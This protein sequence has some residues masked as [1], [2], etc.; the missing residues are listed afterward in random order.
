MTG[1]MQTIAQTEKKAE[2]ITEAA[3]EY[4]AAAVTGL[5]K[6]IFDHQAQLNSRGNTQKMETE[7]GNLKV[8]GRWIT[9]YQILDGT[10][11]EYT[12]DKDRIA[13]A[14]ELAR[15]ELPQKCKGVPDFNK[16]KR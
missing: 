7:F 11:P 12:T 5:K 3:S 16:D 8:V 2:A 10:N 6:F 1:R 9:I 14:I 15:L 13:A 4:Y